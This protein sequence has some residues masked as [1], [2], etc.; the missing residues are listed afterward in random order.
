VAPGDWA[1]PAEA[2]HGRVPDV[3]RRRDRWCDAHRDDGD[4]LP[5]CWSAGRCATTVPTAIDGVLGHYSFD[6]GTPITA[7]HGGRCAP[8]HSVEAAALVG[9]GE[10]AVFAPA[11]PGHHAPATS[12]GVLLVNNAA[13]AAQV[14][15]DGGAAR[16]AVLDVD[17]HHGTAPSRSS[18]SAPTSPSSRSTPTPA[19]E[20]PT[21]SGTPTT[22]R[23]GDGA[24]GN[25]PL[26]APTVT[27]TRAP[28]RA[29][30]WRRWAS[31]RWCC[32]RGRHLDGDPI[33]GFRLRR[34]DFT[35]LGARVAALGLPT[36]VVMEG[37]YAVADLG[38]NVAA[39]LDPLTP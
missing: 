1:G 16:V 7:H 2:V 8:A 19:V 9:A 34:S 3:P 17:Y 28:R 22:G 13:V 14:F 18:G 15:C 37:G 27:P 32:R 10:P 6:A 38:P 24:I 30:G 35:R 5:L 26:P 11:G 29:G 39:V 4:A 12:T 36:V 23:A 25:L 20:Y 21:T 31:R 33:A